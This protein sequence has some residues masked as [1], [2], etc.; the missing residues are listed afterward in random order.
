MIWA[1]W[2]G[3]YP[4]GDGNAREL[5]Y[6]RAAHTAIL[7]DAF[8]VVVKY[9]EYPMSCVGVELT[10]PYFETFVSD[11]VKNDAGEVRVHA[12]LIRKR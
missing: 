8:R 11:A 10:S 1:G 2:A 7:A 4:Y 5:A 6:R 3:A 12:K 9:R